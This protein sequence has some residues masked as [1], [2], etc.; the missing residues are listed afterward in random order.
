MEPYKCRV[1]FGLL[2]NIGVAKKKDRV[3]KIVPVFR[4]KVKAEISI[5]SVSYVVIGR[6][7]NG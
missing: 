2:G 5:Y 4:V 1:A 6:K 7:R 3:Y